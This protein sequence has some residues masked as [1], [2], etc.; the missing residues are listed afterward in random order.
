MRITPTDLED[1]KLIAP[2]RHEDPRG[3]FVR[4]L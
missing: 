2:V 4:N 1:V 3:F